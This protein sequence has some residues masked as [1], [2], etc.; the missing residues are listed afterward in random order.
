M[1]ALVGRGFGIFVPLVTASCDRAMQLVNP[2]LD[3]SSEITDAAPSAMPVT[4]STTFATSPFS[5]GQLDAGSISVPRGAQRDTLAFE[6]MSACFVDTATSVHCYGRRSIDLKPILDHGAMPFYGATSS[7]AAMNDAL[8]ALSASG[9]VE[10]LGRG[11]TGQI[12]DGAL[13]D[14]AKPRAVLDGAVQ[15]VTGIEHACVRFA[16]GRIAC[17]GGDVRSEADTKNDH[18]CDFGP[19]LPKP[20]FFPLRGAAT[21]IVAGPLSVCA[22]EKDGSTECFGSPALP[23]GLPPLRDLALG[24]SSACAL[25]KTGDV[26]CWGKN[27]V[28]Q[29]GVA[30]ADRTDA[31]RVPL[32][33]KAVELATVG[34][35]T[36][37]R[38]AS[39]SIQCWGA[40]ALGQLGRSTVTKGI[41][42]APGAVT[43]PGPARAL[44]GGAAFCA[45]M[46]HSLIC[47]GP[48]PWTSEVAKSIEDPF[49]DGR[50]FSSKPIE[51][52]E[53]AGAR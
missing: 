21:S 38:L 10:C 46:D 49:V 29:T 45:A 43:L 40:N 19:C 4:A 27:D 3:A 26:W 50:D 24:G 2:N 11:T 37:A 28:I 9:R 52:S 14:E 35:A 30:G 39:S 47:W 20:V 17:W 6:A 34:V 22:I 13:K 32:P 36:C 5:V 33:G 44:S 16:D 25:A 53:F 15:L 31:V 7:I 8:C 1:R 51:V 23:K 42:S 12:G 48:R 41:G 18:A